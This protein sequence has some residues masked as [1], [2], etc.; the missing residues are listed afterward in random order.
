MPDPALRV[1]LAYLVIELG[2]TPD[3]HDVGPVQICL[4]VAS[5]ASSVTGYE[6]ELEST[7]DQITQLLARGGRPSNDHDSAQTSLGQRRDHSVDLDR[8]RRP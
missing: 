3:S 6:P 5:R 1:E 8:I 2:A 7:G 4:R